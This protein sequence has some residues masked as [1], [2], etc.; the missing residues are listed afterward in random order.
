MPPAP[1]QAPPLTPAILK[2][3]S[4]EFAVLIAKLCRVVRRSPDG[5]AIAN[6]LFRSA[7]SVAANYRA[8]CR[9]RSLREFV[10]KLGVVVEECDESL[11]WLELLARLSVADPASLREALR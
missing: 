3:R 7:T 1:S 10:A 2:Q 5:R 9:A 8:S 6:Q 11:F 4:M